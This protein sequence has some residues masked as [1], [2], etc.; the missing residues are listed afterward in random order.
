MLRMIR[1]SAGVMVG[2][3]ASAALPAMA[4]PAPPVVA[5]AVQAVVDCRKLTDDGQ[6]LACYDKAVSA[7]TDAQAKGD[8]VTIDR[9]Q[10]QAV[11]RQAFGL[12]LPTLDFL[13][14]GEKPEQVNRLTDTVASVSKTVEGRWVMRMQDGAI[15][16]QTD[17]AELSRDPHVG[18]QV[19]IKKAAL[20]SF[21][22]DI[23]GQPGI[24]AHRDN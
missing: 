15:W 19:V 9:E 17:D 5:P 11:R 16:R 13:D 22:I 6:R 23:D 14:R 3:F 7:M 21:M 18:S 20:G 8:L 4:D 1:G 24:R 10:R 2:L 12:T